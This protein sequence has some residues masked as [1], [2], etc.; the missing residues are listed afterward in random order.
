MNQK[1]IRCFMYCSS[2]IWKTLTKPLLTPT[3]WLEQPAFL[4]ASG[5]VYRKTSLE[6]IKSESD[7]LSDKPESLT[8]SDS[9]DSKTSIESFIAE[10]NA[11]SDKPE[12]LTASGSTDNKT[13]LEFFL[14]EFGALSDKPI[15]DIKETVSINSS[16][17]ELLGKKTTKII[18]KR[19]L[20]KSSAAYL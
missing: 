9:I 18:W 14:A 17:I 20:I 11:L 3:R 2:G 1:F 16:S 10:S 4:A 5:S 15:K 19:R 13:S 7:A 6:G 8:T 12:S